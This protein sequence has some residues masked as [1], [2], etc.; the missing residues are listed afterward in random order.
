MNRNES[1]ELA[2]VRRLAGIDPHE[3][4]D[5]VFFM[6][7]RDALATRDAEIARLNAE[8]ATSDRRLQ[9]HIAANAQERLNVLGSIREIPQAVDISGM[10]YEPEVEDD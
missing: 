9:E 6:L 4:I 3:G 2:E 5:D 1:R 8:L 10:E 7:V